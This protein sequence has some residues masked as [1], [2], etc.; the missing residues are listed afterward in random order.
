[1]MAV[2]NEIVLRATQMSAAFTGKSNVTCSGHS[3]SHSICR[4]YHSQRGNNVLVPAASQ[5][6]TSLI[7][8]KLAF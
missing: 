1:M 4:V 5:R 7:F 3:G 2:M 6:E 8:H